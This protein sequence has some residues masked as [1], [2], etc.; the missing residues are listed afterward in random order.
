MKKYE[1][2][3][4]NGESYAVN[5]ND[6]EGLAV[7]TLSDDT[8]LSADDSGKILLIDTD[9]KTL[10]LPETNEGL[11]YIIV[12]DG[13]DGAVE[14]TVSPD[15]SDKIMGS[16]NNG[17]QKIVMSGTDDKDIVNT[18]ATAKNGD[19]L[20]LVGDGSDGWYIENG[21]GVWTEES[22]TAN[23]VILNPEV[24]ETIEEA[25]TL[26]A[27]DSGKTFFLATGDTDGA[28]ITLPS[29][30]DGVKYKFIVTAT[31]ASTDWT[32]V[33]DDDV[34]EGGAIV[35]STFVAASNEN[36]IS[37][38]AGSETIGDYVELISDG[39]SWFVNGVG[40]GAGS[41]AFTAPA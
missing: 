38:D 12:N 32:I 22:Q 7:K 21:V 39:T 37:F 31:F 18:K 17:G 24:T 4:S 5:A 14:I 2:T 6:G 1:L 9:G 28:E 15:S 33:A 29:P 40:A 13:A 11:R 10:T 25:K 35:D 16:F 36:T 23:D 27:N 34:I 8:T 41:I 3:L 20:V 30:T 26:D 19:L